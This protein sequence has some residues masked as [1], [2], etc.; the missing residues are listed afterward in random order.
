VVQ[1]RFNVDTRHV[2]HGDEVLGAVNTQIDGL[3]D[4]G[5][6]QAGR[7]S[8]FVQKPP[9]EGGVPGQLRQ[10]SLDRH[11]PLE[12]LDAAQLRAKH[13]GHSA[14]LDLLEE[15]IPPMRANQR[16]EIA[17]LHRT[18]SRGNRFLSNSVAR[19]GKRGC[20][21]NTSRT[22]PGAIRR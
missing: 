4:V 14:G 12:T 13:L 6:A 7:Q 22:R 17:A 19:R 5:M 9:D 18:P 20:K 21:K 2:L 16:P 15:L 8:R 11:H 10:D 3:D 1:Q